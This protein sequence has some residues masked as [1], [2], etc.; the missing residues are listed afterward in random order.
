MKNSSE[1][2]ISGKQKLMKDINRSLVMKLVIRSGK[3]GRAELAKLTGLSLPSVMRIAEGLMTE[4]LLEEIGKGASSGGRKPSLLTLKSDAYYI[5]GVE[6]ALRTTVVL[7]DLSGH[8]VEKWESHA[9][10]A[11]SPERMLD[12]IDD[13]IQRMLKAH[14]VPWDR[15]A[16]IGIG[17]PGTN[18]KYLQEMEL[19]II[20]GWEN[21]DV[22]AW[23]EARRRDSR[24][25]IITEN[26]ARTRTLNELWFGL[27]KTLKSFIYVFVDQGVG[28]GFVNNEIIYVGQ[29]DVAGEFGHSL[30]MPGGR[31]CYCGNRGCTEMYVSAGAIAREVK[32]ALHISDRSFGF[33]EVMGMAAEPPVQEILKKSGEMLGYGLA[34]LIN[35]YNPKALILGG[36]VP[37]ASALLAEQA[38]KTAS[39]AVF[40][41]S[42]LDTPMT[43]SAIP[44]SSD[45]LGSVALVINAMFRSVEIQ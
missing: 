25:M 36:E 18:F 26:V 29:N 31:P 24:Y 17:T 41:K 6:I 1:K 9:A 33:S 4:G 21:L 11:I 40:S 44:R 27:G 20:K 38:F 16:G 45:C 28:C 30:I 5:V 42:A 3:I 12:K 19:S 10:A 15:F 8:I 35:L 43:V 7:A 37:K 34:N 39:E 23:F 14:D 32:Q 22:K 2:I 13:E